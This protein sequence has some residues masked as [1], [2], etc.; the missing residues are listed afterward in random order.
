MKGKSVLVLSLIT[1]LWGCG[2][3]EDCDDGLD[4]DRNGLI[5]CADPI[6]LD[7]E[8]RCAACGDGEV[9]SVFGED[10]DDGNLQNGDACDADC[11]F[12][13]GDGSR[14]DEDEVCDDGNQASGDGCEPDCTLT[15]PGCGNGVLDSGEPCDD[16]NDDNKDACVNTCVEARCG[17]GF[18]Q[19]GV[20]ACDDGNMVSGDGCFADCSR[21]EVCGNGFLDPGESC[22]TGDEVTPTCSSLCTLYMESCNNGVRNAGEACFLEAPQ[23]ISIGPDGGDALILAL[24]DLDGDQDLDLAATTRSPDSVVVLLNDGQGRFALHASL[25]VGPAPS[26]LV[27]A[28]LDGDNDLDL[29]VAIGGADLPN[30][31]VVLQN[32]GKA[33]LTSAGAFNTGGKSTKGMDAGDLDGDGDIDLVLGVYANLSVLMNNGQGSFGA[34]ALLNV[35]SSVNDV[36]L[37]S[38][39][40]DGDLDIVAVLDFDDEAAVFINNGAGAFGAP[41]LTPIGGNVPM[42]GDLGDIDGDSDL[43]LVTVNFFSHDAAVLKNN[44]SGTYAV[45]ALAPLSDFGIPEDVVLADIDGDKALDIVAPMDGIHILF[46]D[47]SGSFAAPL[48]FYD[49]F[50]SGALAVGDLNGDGAND[51]AVAE[52][53]IGGDISIYLARP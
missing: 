4:N 16:G 47:G 41:T 32:D 48:T 50:L 43:D 52:G 49:F 14:N 17:D 11:S 20:E 51:L 33:Q 18:T 38:A 9:S 26:P 39:D 2:P 8:L 15:F 1:V 37:G 13:C 40:A 35:N 36:I 10:C 23:E 34:P 24:G 29:A 5:D 30:E 42:A 31:V 44:G 46:N 45:S 53:F 3:S 7:E 28:D 25:S 6:C 22:D 12:P 21:E 27:A 19:D